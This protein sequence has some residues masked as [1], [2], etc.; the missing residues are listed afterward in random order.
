MA[1]SHKLVG[2]KIAANI[3]VYILTRSELLCSLCYEVPCKRGEGQLSPYFLAKACSKFPGFI[4]DEF[5]SHFNDNTRK[6]LF[7]KFGQ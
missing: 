1:L 2:P 3:K 6:K 7:G 4:A 5:V